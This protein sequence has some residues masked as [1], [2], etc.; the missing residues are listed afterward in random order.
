M[1]RFLTSWNEFVGMLMESEFVGCS[2][3]TTYME[4]TQSKQL[5][6]MGAQLSNGVHTNRRTD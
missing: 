3:S 1:F 6:K 2:M 4:Y 5:Y